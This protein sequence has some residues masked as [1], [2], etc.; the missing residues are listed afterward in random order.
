M[1][2]QTAYLR[3]NENK[4]ETPMSELK[5]SH[6]IVQAIRDEGAS[7]VFLIPGGYVDNFSQALVDVN[8]ITPVVCATESGA[9]Y[10]ADG[11]ARS[12]G[13]FGVCMG[14]SGPGAS[15]MLTGLSASYAD[16]VPVL[17]ITGD[18]PLIW[19]NRDAIQDPGSG[20]LKTTHLLGTV[21]QQQFELTHA[22]LA[23]DHLR[24]LMTTLKGPKQGVAHLAVPLDIQRHEQTYD[25]MPHSHLSARST[26]VLDQEGLDLA[27]QMMAENK[28]VVILAGSGVRKANAFAALEA[29]AEFFGIPVATTMSSKGDFPEDHRLSLGVFG[30]AG[31]A[32][33]NEL[34]IHGEID[35]LV[36]VGSRL[37]QINSM[38]WSNKLVAER[39]LIQVD[40]DPDHLNRTYVA[41]LAVV[42]DAEA[43]LRYWASSDKKTLAQSQLLDS[44]PARLQ[45]LAEQ[46]EQHSHCY[47]I[48]DC[49]S[50]SMPLHP[51][52]AIYEL[53][54]AMPIDTQL[55]V[56]NGAHTFFATHYW[57]M[58]KPHQYFNIIKYSGAMGWAI[59]ASIGAKLARP[60]TPVVAVVGDGCMLMQG[61]EIQTAGRYKLSGIIFVV[62]NN[63]AHGNPKLRAHSFT[64]D[65][66]ALTDIV[67]HNWA[68][69][70]ESLGVKG[71][72]VSDPSELGACYSEAL[73]ADGPVLIDV[74]C[75]LFPTP[76]KVFDETFMEEFN[77]YID[78]PSSNQAPTLGDEKACKPGKQKMNVT[79]SDT[80][81]DSSND[82]SNDT[83]T[84]KLND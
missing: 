63:K 8:G 12:A 7:H 61:M 84:L 5:L 69:F 67:D 21:A 31:S 52:R 75:C 81:N 41:D 33:A 9:A 66:E 53:D 30:W 51:A 2:S 40:L 15:N 59:P 58:R 20:G 3:H 13:R 22:K 17:V 36:V 46:R 77:R 73:L 80:S 38:G 47:T 26:R 16:Q 55:F 50:T 18:A 32:L 56:D 29:F 83:K 79:S 78:N 27:L 39:K 68:G 42:S 43:T 60:D 14:I 74:K 35:C 76:T 11:F 70:A 57:T 34:L 62:L 45:W 6:Y 10:M 19:R 1:D 49:H 28:R 54:A 44:K 65:A 25:Y 24:R 37:G 72:T 64:P 48:D 82:S 71:L 23:E 4:S